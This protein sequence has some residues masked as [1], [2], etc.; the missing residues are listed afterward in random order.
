MKQTEYIGAGELSKLAGIVLELAPKK[1]FLVTGRRSYE[2]SGAAQ[3]VVRH[4]RGEKSC[5]TPTSKRYRLKKRCKK[6][7]KRMPRS[8]RI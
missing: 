4:S 1:V 5:T 7:E 2:A 3:K 6:G 8:R